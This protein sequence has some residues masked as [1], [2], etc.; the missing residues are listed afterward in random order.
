VPKKI[1]ADVF[2]FRANAK[3]LLISGRKPTWSNLGGE[4]PKVEP[5]QRRCH[6]VAERAVIG[7]DSPTAVK[8]Y[9]EHF[10]FKFLELNAIELS[11]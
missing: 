1:L 8:R 9:A 3:I 2:G 10:L 6:V 11:G 4:M 7:V 5:N